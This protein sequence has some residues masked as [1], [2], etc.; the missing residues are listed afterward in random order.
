MAVEINN[1]TMLDFF[2]Q[3]GGSLDVKN[4]KNQ[5][6]LEWA[7]RRDAVNCACEL[8]KKGMSL[9]QKNNEG[10]TYVERLLE[11]Q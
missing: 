4:E 8:I 2:V 7:L 10:K 1:V 6:L 9:E 5:D 3:L 11:E